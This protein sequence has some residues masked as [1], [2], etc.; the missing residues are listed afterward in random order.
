MASDLTTYLGNK[1]VRWLAGTDMPTAPAGI[2]VAI[3]DGDPK[4]AGTE[5]TT[6]IRGAGRLAMPVTAPASGTVNTLSSNAD[7]DYGTSGADV[8]ASHV[9]IFDDASAGNMLSSK[10]LSGGPFSILTGEPVK[11]LAGELE[12]IIG[13]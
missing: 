7:V 2:F 1:I 9:A 12:F 4:G 11:F 13:S 8:S 6:S 5:I 3:Y 10:A